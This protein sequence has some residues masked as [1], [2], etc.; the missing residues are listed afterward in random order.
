MV[1]SSVELD[2][3]ASSGFEPWTCLRLRAAGLEP[4]ASTLEPWAWAWGFGPWALGL[5]LG[6]Q[7]LGQ[8]P[9]GRVV[10]ALG[11]GSWVSGL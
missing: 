3:F 7:A 1:I 2:H 8:E 9:L 5:G 10:R 6:P 11:I 4:H